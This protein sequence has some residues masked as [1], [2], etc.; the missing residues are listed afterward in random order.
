MSNQEPPHQDFE[1]LAYQPVHNQAG[2]P[3]EPEVLVARQGFEAFLKMA[4]FVS[5]KDTCV[6][7]SHYLYMALRQKPSAE[8]DEIW[9]AGGGYTPDSGVR[10]KGGGF[11]K[12]MWVGCTVQGMSWVLD[13]SGDQFGLNPTVI[14]HQESA[15]SV[16]REDSSEQMRF[17]IQRIHQDDALLDA[18]AN[19]GLEPKRSVNKHA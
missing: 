3:L 15:S 7:A 1:S 11:T 12:H 8:I 6:Y 4:G 13:I 19:A 10:L 14:A 18:M 9:L 17:L 16:Y 2:F 5:S